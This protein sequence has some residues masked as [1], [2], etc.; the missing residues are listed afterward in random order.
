LKKD[1]AK[2]ALFLVAFFLLS[3]GACSQS[4]NTQELSVHSP[5]RLSILVQSG[6]SE[7]GSHL[8]IPHYKSDDF[9]SVGIDNINSVI[10]KCEFSIIPF[11]DLEFS[12]FYSREDSTKSNIDTTMLRQYQKET[13]EFR[14]FKNKLAGM[15][16]VS[17]D[18]THP[19]QKAAQNCVIDTLYDW[20]ENRAMTGKAT[21]Q[22][23][24]VRQWALSVMALS[25]A[26]A[27]TYGNISESNNTNGKTETIEQWLSELALL[28]MKRYPINFHESTSLSKKNNLLYWGAW[29]VTITAVAVDNKDFYNWGMHKAKYAI[30]TGINNEGYF[31]NELK[32]GKKAFQYHLFAIA[33]LIMIA[34]TAIANGDDIYQLNDNAIARIVENIVLNLGNEVDYS[35]LTGVIQDD[36]GQISKEHFAWME[37]YNARFTNE[38]ITDYLEKNR[39]FIARRLGGHMTNIYIDAKTYNKY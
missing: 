22:G 38:I 24:F 8:N 17:L 1:K 39:P 5:Y 11:R 12:S 20:A 35:N 21:P 3:L 19:L 16:N 27:R 34:E 23:E 14:S 32:R 18:T 10:K 15:A 26:Q 2:Q 13:S 9:A 37:V 36:I 25:Y 30:F 4:E 33:P 31:I 29:A 6:K 7:D 28:V